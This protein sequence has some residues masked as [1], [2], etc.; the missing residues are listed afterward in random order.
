MPDS[1][2]MSDLLG[3]LLQTSHTISPDDLA[4]AVAR[5]SAGAGLADVEI[6][7]VDLEQRVLTQ[8]GGDAVYD[9]EGTLAGRA[10]RRTEPVEAPADDGGVRV[11]QPMLDGAERLGVLA[12]TI[13][14]GESAMDAAL[15]RSLATLVSLLVVAK[16]AFGDAIAS[17]RS[18]QPMTLA[19]EL[20]W[21][22]LPPLT[23]TG[24]GIT[25]A[26]VLEPAYRVA[27]DA[28]DYGLGDKVAHL[29]IFDA[30][31][32][33][34]EAARLANLAL[35]TF[36]HAR[37]AEMGPVEM[38]E[39]IDRTVT[40]Q[41]GGNVFLTGQ[42]ARLEMATGRLTLLNAGHPP[43]MLLRGNKYVGDLDAAPWLPFGLGV[44]ESEPGELAETSLEPGD[45]VLFLTDG[46]VEARSSDGEQFGRERLAD[47]LARAAADMVTLPETMRRLVHAVL[48][49]HSGE[50][51]D[52]ATLL[53]VEWSGANDESAHE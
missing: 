36:R 9:L 40:G 39:M 28:F 24:R 35:A 50:L 17:R 47:F 12:A 51:Q 46:V 11:Y 52:D 32:H 26:G 22:F 16:S 37:R 34:L 4:P 49:H 53:L 41:F 20:R 14:D 29:A 27:G 3:A 25:V 45:R 18:R 42:T 5:L 15:L 7:L 19:A 6:L 2:P 38:Y 21:S 8:L 23:F 33:G 30:M 48:A 1:G 44:D 43:P 10:F 31:G 13:A